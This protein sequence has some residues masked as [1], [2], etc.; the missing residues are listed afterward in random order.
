MATL[1]MTP[2]AFYKYFES[3]EMLAQEVC[4]QAFSDA[5]GF[6]QSTIGQALT[7]STPLHSVQSDYW[8]ALPRV[9]R[10]TPQTRSFCDRTSELDEREP[11]VLRLSAQTLSA[12]LTRQENHPF[13]SQPFCSRPFMMAIIPW[14]DSC[15]DGVFTSE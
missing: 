8:V 12:L 5:L 6:R 15:N 9:R 3:K 2:S 4:E 7:W 11:T 13:E 1:G 14:R 10:R